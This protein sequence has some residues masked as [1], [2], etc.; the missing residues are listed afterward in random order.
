MRGGTRACAA[1]PTTSSTASVADVAS[2]G[3]REKPT[4]RST[5]RVR[6]WVFWNHPG[7]HRSQRPSSSS[8]I[9]WPRRAPAA[10][11]PSS[12]EEQPAGHLEPRQPAGRRT[13]RP[14]LREVFGEVRDRVRSMALVHENCT[15]RGAGEAQLQHLRQEPDAVALDAMAP[16][17][18]A[19]SFIRGRAGG[20]DGRDGRSVR[21]DPE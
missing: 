8:G 12:G 5:M 15:S 6:C 21:V 3:V 11:D 4:W 19:C 10:R 7:H 9:R 18:D 2:S 16:R 17:R 14:A 13:R 20:V 1:S